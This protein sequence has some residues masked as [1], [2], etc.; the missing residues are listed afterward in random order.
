[1]ICLAKNCNCISKENI[2]FLDI[3]LYLQFFFHLRRLVNH[4]SGNLKHELNSHKLLLSKENI[5]FFFTFFFIFHSFFLDG[6]QNIYQI[7]LK[8]L[9]IINLANLFSRENLIYFF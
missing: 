4:L 7:Y 9:D 8:I 6:P 2:N 1:M 5:F 3:F